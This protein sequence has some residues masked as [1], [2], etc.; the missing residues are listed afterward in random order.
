M[1]E[2]QNK[3]YRLTH[4]QKRIGY[5][6]K[7]Y[8]DSP[9]HTIG[10]TLNFKGPIEVEKLERAI[11]I[12]IQNNE[13]LRLNFREMEGDLYQFIRNYDY[14]DIDFFDFT[15]IKH[16]ENE[17]R[18]W[19]KEIFKKRFELE[20]NKLYYFAIYK[21]SNNEYGFVLA[22]H[23]II[24]DGWSIALIERQICENYHKLIRSDKP[25][26]SKSSYLDFIKS[27]DEYINSERYSK[28]K[29]Y[30]NHKFSDLNTEFLYKSSEKLEGNRKN[31]IA[32]QNISIQ[33]KK[34][35]KDNNYTLNDFI[36]TC[37]LI[38]L[39][40]TSNQ[41]DI[42]IGTP[43]FNRLGKAEKSLVGMFTS[44]MPFRFTVNNES[45]FTELLI[46]VKKEMKNCYR[47]QRYPYDLL[48]KDLELNKRG[49]DSLFT[50]SVNCYNSEF[51][52]NIEGIELE[53]EE[54][55]SGHQN[56][57]LQLVIKEEKNDIIF[58]F[59]Y[60]LSEYLEEDIINMY[61]CIQN[62]IRQ[63]I[64]SPNTHFKDIHLLDDNERFQK[65][66]TFNSTNYT[67]PSSSTVQE[68]FELQVKSNPEKIALYLENEYLTYRQ[69][70]EKSNQLANYLKEVGVNKGSNV[71]IMTAHSFELIIGILG[72][73]KSGGTYVPIDPSYPSGRIEYI[74]NDS[75]SGI[76][77]ADIDVITNVDF[78]GSIVNLKGMTLE[79][80]S[81][82]NLNELES[83]EDI[84][85]IIYTSGST[86]KP[87]GVLVEQKGLMNY[88]SW[89]KRKY[90]KD[91]KEIFALYSSISFDLTITSIFTPLISSTSIRIYH[92]GD[93]EFILYKVLKENKSTLIKLTPSH[94]S[95]LKDLNYE[96]S[97]VRTFVV[98]GEDL[99]TTLASE[100]YESF[101]KNIDIYNEYGPTET[102]VGCMWY[103]YKPVEYLRK[104]VPIGYPADNVQIYILNKDLDVLPNGIPGEIYISGDGVS[105]GY[106]NQEELTK[107]RFL[108]NPF[109]NGQRMYKTG[110]IGTYLADGNIEYL[111]R[112]D[113][114]V[115]IRGHRI[116]IA[117]IESCILENKYVK[118][119][120]VLNNNP[121]IL[122]AYIIAEKQFENLEIKKWLSQFLP[123][124]MIPNNYICID[125]F[126][127]TS[128]G[129]IDF[130]LLPKVNLNENYVDGVT[131]LEK[132]L[133]KV[134][135]DVLN[136]KKVSM[137]D[138]FFQLGGDSIKAIQIVGKLRS[139][140]MELKVNNILLSDKLADIPKYIIKK[141]KS[142]LINKDEYAG[143]I[144]NTP[145]TNWFFN[146]NFKNDN[147]YN[148]Y[149]LLEISKALNLDKIKETVNH[150]I[151]YHDMLRVNYD[152][153][154]ATLY[155][156]D[157]NLVDID[158]VDYLDLSE[159][160]QVTQDEVISNSLET[161]FN[162]ENN[163]NFRVKVFDLGERG[164]ALLFIAHH[165]MVD[166]FSWRILIEDFFAVIDGIN[167]NESIIP[168][169][170][171]NSYKK[172][173]NHLVEYSKQEFKEEK[174]YWTSILNKDLDTLVLSA[175][176]E[177][178]TNA[179][180]I[181]IKTS[182][183][184]TRI[185][186]PI[187]KANDIYNIDVNELLVIGLVLTLNKFSDSNEVIIEL[188]RHG[189]ENFLESLDVSRTVGWFTSIFPAYFTVDQNSLESKMMSIKEQLRQVPNKGF[190]YS[191]LRYLKNEIDGD[192]KKY[193]R[194]NYIGDF[195]DFLKDK[196]NNISNVKFGLDSDE[197][198][199]MTALLDVMAILVDEKL[200]LSFTY[201][202]HTLKKE[203]AEYLINKYITVL[204]EIFDHC[205]TKLEREYTPS[206][207]R[208]NGMTQ[209]DLDIMFN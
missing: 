46:A 108:T 88:L 34:Y 173:A 182:M 206:D 171:T 196:E 75:N 144:T 125:E 70:N 44:T 176:K 192:F 93:N 97:S 163:L 63:V 154:K 198:N 179:N 175:E 90:V 138:N 114:Q 35:L 133:L 82:N 39:G 42:T 56:Y 91:D 209:E 31:F 79:S 136:L 152:R 18:T 48:I 161:D 137:N 167:N 130:S 95:L 27:E 186:D 29:T 200:E 80:Y 169:L 43:I 188:E 96:N 30:W 199:E 168:Y 160:N 191:I 23:H 47:N 201:N 143:K 204:L 178:S 150:L 6:D 180:S 1:G 122:T 147:H 38:Y 208:V 86:G 40:K 77:L 155:Y 76:L 184:R 105:K 141:Q 32:E 9:L 71:A 145:I 177:N 149:V 123:Q 68:I 121:N 17:L 22:I 193:I 107:E 140:D 14:E 106:L 190:N 83:P 99:K 132:E 67:Y 187:Q 72:I 100:I 148:Q 87:K 78:E 134:I 89:A 16:S 21:K 20:D 159:R 60:K 156:K 203:K 164:Q 202:Q 15:T 131:D 19:V 117:E 142:N 53:I 124:F 115:K 66:F 112:A 74:L 81:K 129:K 57:P 139:L 120:V 2:E 85:Y 111:G 197:S 84:A 119:V 58:S 36:L 55:Y 103:K 126:P 162:L 157:L 194:F 24:A 62:I 165:L 51:T 11:N 158:V 13:G 151:E 127:L 98:G 37:A 189:R 183:D 101:N 92:N 54:Y 170:K 73:L 128:N 61:E 195:N 50:M 116:E 52:S 45:P 3:Y 118:D 59:D 102:V 174:D 94:L 12:T 64:D 5:I 49:F 135:G 28:N 8:T 4:P 181:T 33:L 41:D 69:L 7:I 172:W 104:S 109:I 110:D 26:T 25:I 65:I 185:I 113:S 205:L 153:E 10:G 207:F 166:G 146:Q